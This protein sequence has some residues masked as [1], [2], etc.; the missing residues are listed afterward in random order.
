MKGNSSGWTFRQ[1]L[2]LRDDHETTK[3]Q[4]RFVDKSYSFFLVFN[5]SDLKASKAIHW[6]LSPNEN[7]SKLIRSDKSLFWHVFENLF[8]HQLYI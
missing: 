2:S 5:I 6:F 4:I 1:K 8:F 3:F 7:F